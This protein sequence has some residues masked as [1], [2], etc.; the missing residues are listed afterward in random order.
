MKPQLTY[1]SLLSVYLFL[2]IS[3]GSYYIKITPRVPINHYEAKSWTGLINRCDPEFP[4]NDGWL[5]GDGNVSVPL[6]AITTLF[7]FSDT[8]VGQNNQVSRKRGVSMIANSVAIQ[9]CLSPNESGTR[10]FWNQMYTESPQPVFK[11]ANPEHKFWVKDAFI[12]EGKLYVLLEEIGPKYDAT[13]DDLFNFTQLG[14]SL[15][16]I[17]NPYEVPFLWKVEYITL[18]DFKLPLMEISCHARLNDYLYFFIN[19]NDNA[20]L[21]VR[22]PVENFDDM[23]IPFE[24]FALDKSWEKGLDVFDMD[25]VLNGFRCNTVKYHSDIKQWVMV[26]DIWFKSDQIK[27]RTASGLTGPWSDEEVIYTIPETSKGNTL[28][29]KDNFCYQARESIQNYDSKTQEMLITYDINNSNLSKVLKNN[30]IY[31]P[32]VIRVKLPFEIEEVEER[33]IQIDGD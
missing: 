14:Y 24:Y 2:F 22:K 25:T 28:Y 12:I 30:A 6:D 19:R 27:I 26:H 17:T 13:P 4:F 32:K 9:T 1:S 11:P 21:L 7:L 31:T 16:K 29:R 18:Q 23:S 20:Q 10:Y 3:C 5:G 8:Y 33:L 15:A